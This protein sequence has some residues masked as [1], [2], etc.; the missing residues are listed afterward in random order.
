MAVDGEIPTKYIN[1]V[2]D[3]SAW[4][5]G[6][7]PGS[8]TWSIPRHPRPLA[9]CVTTAKAEPARLR[10]SMFREHACS[11][12]D[13]VIP[14]IADGRVVMEVLDRETFAIVEDVV[15]AIGLRKDL[16]EKACA[17]AGLH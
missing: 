17:I 11:C 8:Q 14:L 16:A 5:G 2:A 15:M 10:V 1:A 12:R 4:D 13:N 7:E 3:L 9:A 6:K